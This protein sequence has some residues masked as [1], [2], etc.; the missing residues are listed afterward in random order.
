MQTLSDV[1][2]FNWVVNRPMRRQN[3][4]CTVVGVQPTYAA[5]EVGVT[6]LGKLPVKKT[7]I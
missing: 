2:I 6:Y 7:N 3:G 4:K 1:C 5:T